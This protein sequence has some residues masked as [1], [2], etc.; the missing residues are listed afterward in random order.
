MVRFTVFVAFFIG[1]GF[2]QSPIPHRNYI[3][4]YIFGKMEKDRVRPAPL[5]SD[6]E[7]LRRVSLDLTGRLPEPKA[8]RKFLADPD[9]NK[10]DKLIDSLFPPIPEVGLGRRE[11]RVGPFF[12]RWSY[13]FCD[14]FRAND[15]MRNGAVP[16][17]EY[18]FELR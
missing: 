13:F 6:A 4:D 15:L 3:D 1:L 7:F 10:R 17:H 11:T 5:A 9:P 8:V 2:A 16:F 14:L 12:D 18:I